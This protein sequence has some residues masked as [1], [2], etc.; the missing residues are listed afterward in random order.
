MHAGSISWRTVTLNSK[1]FGVI[2]NMYVSRTTLHIKL[3]PTA[4]FLIPQR[5]LYVL[6]VCSHPSLLPTT[7]KLL[8]FPLVPNLFIL[9]SLLE[10]ILY[11]RSATRGKLYC[12]LCKIASRR[13]TWGY[14]SF[15]SPLLGG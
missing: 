11:S 3:T 5:A 2:Q 12:K 10:G 4:L 8:S 13:E 6:L 7:A 1:N 9:L 14:F 15:L